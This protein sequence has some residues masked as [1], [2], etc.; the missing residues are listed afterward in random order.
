MRRISKLKSFLVAAAA[1][2]SALGL[3][4]SASAAGTWTVS[5]VPSS[6]TW[7]ANSTNP[8]LNDPNTG[9][10]LTCT[11]SSVSGSATNG[12]GLSGTGILRIT[13]ASWSSCSGPLGITFTVTPQNLPWTVNV[14]SYDPTT[15]VV[16]GTITGVEAHISGVG[17]TADIRGPSATTPGTLNFTYNNA[18]HVLTITGGNL[19]LYNVS[20]SCLGLL[21]SGDP[22]SYTGSYTLTVW[23]VLTSP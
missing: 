15:G 23:I 6:G 8:M 9:T 4:T 10:Q 1:L 11:S 13:A 18:T 17:C 2:F 5:G 12:S 21:N 20:G 14:I 7:S 19:H 16:T 3:A 22:V